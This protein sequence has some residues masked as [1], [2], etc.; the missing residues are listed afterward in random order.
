MPQTA[1]PTCENTKSGNMLEKFY[2]NC[3]Y[4][5]SLEVG[6]GLPNNLLKFVDVVI[7]KGCESQ[8]CGN[9]DCNSYIFDGATRIYQRCSML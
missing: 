7:E 9:K 5:G 3:R 1:P 6:G 8:G 4:T 2:K